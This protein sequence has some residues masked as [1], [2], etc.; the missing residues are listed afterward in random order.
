MLVQHISP[1]LGL[2]RQFTAVSAC[3]AHASLDNCSSLGTCPSS[4]VWP[5]P[6]TFSL[7]LSYVFTIQFQMVNLGTGNSTV[8]C[9]VGLRT[10]ILIFWTHIK[11]GSVHLLSQFWGVRDW[12]FLRACWQLNLIE[13]ASSRFRWETLTQEIKWTVIEEDTWHWMW[14]STHT[15]LTHAHT[16]EHVYTQNYYSRHFQIIQYFCSNASSVKAGNS[17]YFT[18]FQ[19]RIFF[20]SFN[21]YLMKMA[22]LDHCT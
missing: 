18:C 7:R 5:L 16:R 6:I 2:F 14:T 8:E 22:Y 1:Q 10:W 21:K 4:G 3:E 13:L 11:Y 17:G 15:L 9:F 19:L 12:R 20:Y